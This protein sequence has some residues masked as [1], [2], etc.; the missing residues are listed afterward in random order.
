MT[1]GGDG[2]AETAGKPM[3]EDSRSLYLEGFEEG[4]RQGAEAGRRQY[5]ETFAGTSIIIPAR[6]N[7]REL[8]RCLDSMERHTR[9][10]H[11]IIVVD[12]GSADGTGA[13]LES[14][15]GQVRFRVLEDSSLGLAGALNAGLMM[16]KGRT[17]VLLSA[18]T[19]VTR[20]WLESLRSSLDSDPE[21]VLAGPAVGG[22]QI[23]TATDRAEAVAAAELQP[24]CLAMRR[25][26]FEE[27]GYWDEGMEAE[28]AAAD[29]HLRLRMSGKKL[30]IARGAYVPF[31][32]E[33]WKAAD[34]PRRGLLW[35]K[36]NDPNAWIKR[37]CMNAGS[38]SFLSWYPQR[39]VVQG[40]GDTR[41]WIDRGMKHPVQGELTF[42][43]VR[44][45]QMDLRRWKTGEPI[46]AENA[47]RRWRGMDDP[48]GWEAGL[49]ILPDGSMHHLEGGEYRPLI[50]RRALECWQLHLKPIRLVSWG[51]IATRREGMPIAPLPE[52]RQRL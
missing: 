11:E 27:V 52:I 20:D 41:Y 50:S 5:G 28:E 9:L 40:L 34:V 15:R 30:M 33:S 19:V 44:V 8:R 14:L 51:E 1:K 13:Y 32:G 25:E 22:E 38:R 36:W 46:S 48:A 47:E 35:N 24:Y 2:V 49:A 16:A 17:L 45:T 3:K 29:F 6:D 7:L 12:R 37:A 23:R 10:P 18:D 43:V 4:W 42:P 26:V 31:S 21:A 39:V